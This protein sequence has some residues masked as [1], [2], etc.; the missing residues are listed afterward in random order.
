M[1]AAVVLVR[2]SGVLPQMGSF[3]VMVL[4]FFVTTDKG[5]EQSVAFGCSLSGVWRRFI[6]PGLATPEVLCGI[7]GA[8]VRF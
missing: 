3:A 2:W 5:A 4:V 6:Q 7:G 1:S 8:P